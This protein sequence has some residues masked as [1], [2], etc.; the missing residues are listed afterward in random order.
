ME[1]K[2]NSTS[3]SAIAGRNQQAKDIE[4]PDET[5]IVTRRVA[6]PLPRPGKALHGL[7]L[8]PEAPARRRDKPRRGHLLLVDSGRPPIMPAAACHCNVSTASDEWRA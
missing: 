3:A 8:R 5:S 1:Q 4:R 7:P 6:R 2:K